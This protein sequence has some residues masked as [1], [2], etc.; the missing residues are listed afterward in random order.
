MTKM[1]RC[2]VALIITIGYVA[3]IMT[4]RVSVDSYTPIVM[5]VVKKLMDT[6]K[7]E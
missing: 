5:Y 3:M 4:G 1:T 6:I 2:A 7:G